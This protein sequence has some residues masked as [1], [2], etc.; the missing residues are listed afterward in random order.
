MSRTRRNAHKKLVE[1]RIL[2]T[3]IHRLYHKYKA[4]YGWY[5]KNIPTRKGLAWP[6]TYE[7]AATFIS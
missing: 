4:L 7:G 3:R 2:H 6:Q 5:K 1:R